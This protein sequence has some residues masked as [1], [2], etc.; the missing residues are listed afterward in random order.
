MRKAKICKKC[1]KEYIPT[2]TY[3]FYC[4]EC[5]PIV[6]KERYKVWIKNHPEKRAEIDKRYRETHKEEVKER[7]K[8]WEKLHPDKRKKYTKRWQELHP[9]KVKK[10]MQDWR[11]NN[12]DKYKLS[13][14]R[15]KKEHPEEVKRNNLLRQKG[16]DFIELNQKQ[17]GYE[18]HHID[19]K[20]VIWIPKEIHRSIY[21]S[22]TTGKGMDEINAL[23][24]NYIGG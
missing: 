4:E 11:I 22:Q 10:I 7:A 21:H 6:A 15:W 16:L 1:G 19:K 17:E 9:D 20:Y 5:M 23:A 13:Y 2:G 8:R 14:Q 24:F 3:Q 12:P 18:A